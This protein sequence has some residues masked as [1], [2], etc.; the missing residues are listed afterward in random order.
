MLRCAF[1]RSVFL[2]VT[3]V[4][5]CRGIGMCCAAALVTALRVLPRHW[6]LLFT[7]LAT[8][9][10]VVPLRSHFLECCN[11]PDFS[12]CSFFSPESGAS[13]AQFWMFLFLHIKMPL[14]GAPFLDVPLFYFLTHQDATFRSTATPTTFRKFPLLLRKA[15]QQTH[16]FWKPFTFFITLRC[17]FPKR[18]NFFRKFP[19]LL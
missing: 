15:E 5:L 6:R 4:F 9:F 18:R 13:D 11:T 17:H 2:H 7:A 12:G 3:W 19:F 8:V 1:C 14:S 16:H 10:C